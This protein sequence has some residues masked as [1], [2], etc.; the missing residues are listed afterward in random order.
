MSVGA[1][2]I[3]AAWRLVAAHRA[4]PWS[5]IAPLTGL[6]GA[7][8]VLTGRVALSPRVEPFAATL[9]GLGSGILFYGAT[10]GFVLIARRWPVFDRHVA[11][12]Y[13]QRRGVSLP[14][15]VVLA[16]GVTAPGE[17]LFWRGL[18]Q[19]VLAAHAGWWAAAGM[20]WA[21]YAG[22]V[23]GSGSLPIV[24]GGIVG[25]VIWGGLAVWTH[26]VLAGVACHAMWTSLMLIAPPGGATRTPRA[27]PPAGESRAT[28]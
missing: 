10:V 13:G 25:G 21:S 17:E 5:L 2:A 8:A 27:L 23:S 7:G 11:E 19:G 28:R 18:F 1:M 16:A 3:F 12:I 14:G 15:A 4:T 9:A 6:L 22:A 24:T 20:T 26:G